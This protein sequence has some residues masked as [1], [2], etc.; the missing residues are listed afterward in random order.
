MFRRQ[1][2]RWSSGGAVSGGLDVLGTAQSPQ[3]TL[4]YV[5]PQPRETLNDV[6]GYLARLDTAARGPPR[7]ER[8]IGRHYGVAVHHRKAGPDGDPPVFLAA[9][10]DVLAVH[11]GTA[12]A[13]VTTYLD[14]FR[15]QYHHTARS[16]VVLA[17]LEMHMAAAV[18]A[19]YTEADQQPAVTEN[20]YL[21]LME[22]P[23]VF[24]LRAAHQDLTLRVG[25]PSDFFRAVG[26]AV[27]A[28]LEDGDARSSL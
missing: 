17:R 2:E 27:R 18:R 12:S 21:A 20:P 28:G 8:D 9:A 23:V 16:R 3:V 22:R 6:L 14:A 11:F 25:L 26:E 4:A 13:P 15:P 19:G 5:M 10:G 24:E 7:L 1:L